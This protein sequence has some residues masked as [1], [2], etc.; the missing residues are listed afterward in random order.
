MIRKLIRKAIDRALRPHV[1]RLLEEM[2][3]VPHEDEDCAS[4]DEEDYNPCDGCP[5][6]DRCGPNGRLEPVGDYYIQAR[7]YDRWGMN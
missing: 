4:C 1:A 3:Q 5:D 2:A 7:P 6:A